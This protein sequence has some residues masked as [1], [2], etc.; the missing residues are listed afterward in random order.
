MFR[1]GVR[2]GLSRHAVNPSMGAR[3]A[4]PPLHGLETPYPTPDLSAINIPSLYGYAQGV[5][6]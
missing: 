4:G 3:I 5:D 1:S 2:Y 6:V